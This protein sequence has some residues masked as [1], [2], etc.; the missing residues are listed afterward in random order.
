MSRAEASTRSAWA[1]VLAGVVAALQVGKLPP[2]LQALQA[3][4]GMSLVQSGFMLSMVQLAGMF[5]AIVV[6]M[7]A[8]GAGLKR[9]ML[10]GLAVQ[11]LAGLAGG[12]SITPQGLL[13][14]RA[15]EGLGFLLVVL[16]G[17]ALIR[18]LVLPSSLSG[19]LGVWGTYMPIGTALT[20]LAGP[21]LI[22][23]WGWPLW[24]DGVALVSALMALVLWRTVPADPVR[25]A[26]GNPLS[27]S[28]QRLW[29][30]L[31]ARGPWLVALIFAVY[32]AQ[33]LAIIGFLPT[34]Y[35]QA[36]WSG[37][38]LGWLT[39]LVAG[40]NLLG[41]LASG[42]CLQRGWA[43]TRLLH[44]GFA[45]M[46]LGALLAFSAWTDGRA[47]LR[48]FGVLLFSSVGGL[49][50]GT[51]FSMAVHLSPGQSHVATTVGWAQQWSAIGQFLGPP[52]VA[53]LASQ[54]GGFQH[55]HWVTISCCL[56]GAVLAHAAGNEMRRRSA[57]SS[58]F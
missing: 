4:V 36:G 13:V 24:W 25:W 44:I 37:A 57:S 3:D 45:A 12:L 1:V 41:N 31:S 54:A 35:A 53:W 55:T 50:P 39:A 56:A 22:P 34:I 47:E 29:E 19:M 6:G 32:S 27:G 15:V 28:R 21:M 38:A 51:L 14:W 20:L 26:P 8:D 46:A 5:L 23:A 40:V 52:L 17:P 42:R 2:A 49:V 33:W 7:V 43:G 9:C 18:R 48:L 16:P 10:A 30:T 58:S 11:A